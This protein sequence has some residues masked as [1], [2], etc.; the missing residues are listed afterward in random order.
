MNY[1]EI[2]LSKHP[3]NTPIFNYSDEIFESEIHSPII[4]SAPLK[5][6]DVDLVKRTLICEFLFNSN[7]FYQFILSVDHNY[8]KQLIENGEEW[9]G[10]NLNLNTINNIFKN[11]V[12]LPTKIPTLPYLSF[13]LSENCEI[14]D[15]GK[16]IKLNDMP[17]N[18]EV[19]LFFQ[20]NSLR[21]FKHKCYLEYIVKKINITN[22]TCQTLDSL[23]EDEN[24]NDSEDIKNEIYDITASTFN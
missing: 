21:Y 13:K 24:L 16:K 5:F 14:Y 3:L 22:K 12:S 18:T 2:N 23:F 4:K 6:L 10:G 17:L 20:I 9:F 11:S 7:D 8:K 19:E 1:N 15:C